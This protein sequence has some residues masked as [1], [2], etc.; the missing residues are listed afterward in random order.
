MSFIGALSKSL[1]YNMAG[2]FVYNFGRNL[3][4]IDFADSFILYFYL[5][6]GLLIFVPL[7]QA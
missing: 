3:K 5:K 4:F 6:S 1:L 7:K 2:I